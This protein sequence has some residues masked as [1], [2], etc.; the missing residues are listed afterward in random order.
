[1][2]RNHL[3]EQP[4]EVLMNFK[5]SKEL[6]DNLRIVCKKEMRNMSVV[7]RRLIQNYTQPRL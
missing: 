3:E 6:A 7:V 4:K 1:M 2:Q 5:F